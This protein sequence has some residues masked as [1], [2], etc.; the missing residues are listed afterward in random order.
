MRKELSCT[1]FSLERQRFFLRNTRITATMI[2]AAA[3]SR[4]GEAVGTGL[5]H[6]NHIAITGDADAAD[7]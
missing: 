6:Q 4:I 2:L 7:D 3:S 5:V 1:L